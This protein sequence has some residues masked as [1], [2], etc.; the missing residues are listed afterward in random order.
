MYK[1][2]NIKFKN[3]EIYSSH[4]NILHSQNDVNL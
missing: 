4:S 1:V 3:I 2:Y